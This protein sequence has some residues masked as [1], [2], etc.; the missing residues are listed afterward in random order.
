MASVTSWNRLEPRTRDARL[1]A[2]QARIADPLWLLGRQWQI[3]EL[4]GEDAGSPVLAQLQFTVSPLS[5]WTP[6]TPT[7]A[8]RRLPPDMPLDVLVE[9][10]SAPGPAGRADLR[11]AL[12]A[13]RR[14]LDLLG[15]RAA[16]LAGPLAAAYGPLPP[17]RLVPADPEAAWLRA[18]AR[19]RLPDARRMWIPLTTWR[20]G[21]GNPPPE[22]NAG[23]QAVGDAV[24]IWLDWYA[25]RP[26]GGIAPAS[27]R[28]ERLE[29][30]FSVA[31]RTT[32]PGPTPAPAPTETVLVATDHGGRDL[33]WHAVDVWAGETLGALADPAPPTTSIVTLPTRVTF[34]G[35]PVARWWQVEEG[36]VDLTALRPG[37]EDLGRL[38]FTEFALNYGNDFFWLP[39]DLPVGSVTKIEELHV[40]TSFGDMVQIRT[41]A[42]ADLAAG[43]VVAGAVPWAMFAPTVRDTGGASG[44]ADLLVL[45]PVGDQPLHSEPVEEILLSRD[46]MADVAWALE[47]TV[48]GPSGSPIDR[49]ELWQRSRPDPEPAPGVPHRP[50]LAYDLAT[51]VP[52]YWLPLLNRP[53]PAGSNRS[54]VLEL[55]ALSPTLG[56]L[57][58]PGFTLHEERLTRTGIRLLRHLKRAR[59]TDGRVHVWTARR[60]SPGTGESTSGLRFDTLRGE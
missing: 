13:G 43:R 22:F 49:H 42:L 41:T 60:A 54:V 25:R 30:E 20:S 34:P 24:D 44:V 26:A 10:E 40:T 1:T 52:P 8:A 29:Y 14:L 15:A 19:G 57:L 51:Q 18:L 5:R 12:E 46:E 47:K 4:Q 16:D 53:G 17:D 31:A 32:G 35:M 50:S 58:G 33:D 21:G 39:F 3:G 38:L 27:W 7:A 9:A 37:P 36:D 45:L 6:S 55:Q 56:S 59:G 48:P 28:P 23:D 11:A 2:V